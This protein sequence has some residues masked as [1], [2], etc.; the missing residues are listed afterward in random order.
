MHEPSIALFAG[1]DGLDAIRSI[2][3]RADAHLHAGGWLL[4]EHA[5]DQAKVV[6]SLLAD[7]EFSSIATY[8]DLS[9]QQRVTEGCWKQATA[10]SAI[11]GERDSY[12]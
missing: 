5:N 12:D 6:R 8:R 4:L 2:I 9:G 11:G 1:P 7:L 10:G 3:G